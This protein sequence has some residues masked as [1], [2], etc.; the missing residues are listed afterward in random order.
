MR[1][2][3]DVSINLKRRNI[4]K[5]YRRKTMKRIATLAALGI[6]LLGA[7]AFAA[8]LAYEPFSQAYAPSFPGDGADITGLSAGSYG[9]T[10]GYHD[11]SAAGVHPGSLTNPLVSSQGNLLGRI[12]GNNNAYYTIANFDT[13]AG[14]TFGSNGYLEPSG[15]M[16]N[17]TGNNI[18]AAGTTLYF[19]YLFASISGD[20]VTGTL[21]L[22]RN[23]DSGNGADVALSITNTAST[24]APA[25]NLYV[26]EIVFGTG[27][28][29]TLYS[30]INPT[31]SSDLTA[32]SVP[33]A[34]NFSFD[35]VE[36]T[37]TGDFQYD[38]LRMGST[39]GDVASVPEPASLS[40][41]AIG[42]IGLLS[43]RRRHA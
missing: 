34:D 29:D 8:P 13:T 41:L 36:F 22:L 4:S 37:G 11:G 24:T 25:A 21:N 17:S 5:L 19:S 28:S 16:V 18:G 2:R 40:V 7:R 35:R 33:G 30:A 23:G 15:T 1:K 32:V 10:G 39:F 26:G 20:S 38:E 43:R 14:G 42:G 9:F 3:A 27:D 6:A 12:S 31:S